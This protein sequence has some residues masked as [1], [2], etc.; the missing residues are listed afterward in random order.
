VHAAFA[1]FSLGGAMVADDERPDILMEL[2]L[3]GWGFDAANLT[4]DSLS[5]H[6]APPLVNSPVLFL[7]EMR[8]EPI[9]LGWILPGGMFLFQMFF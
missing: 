7:P 8:K 1:E 9:K 3:P 5:R 2:H 6:D 4:D